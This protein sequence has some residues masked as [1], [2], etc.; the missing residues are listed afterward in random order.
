MTRRG[1]EIE[2]EL[3]RSDLLVKA[4]GA[5]GALYGLGAL[6]PHVRAAMAAS[7][8]D[9]GLL[10]FMLWFEYMQATLYGRGLSEL[11]VKGEKMPLKSEEKDLFEMLLAQERQHIA[12]VRETIEKLGGKPKREDQSEF[13]FSFRVFETLLQLAGV[14]E[15]AAVGAYNGAIPLLK[16]EEARELA[17]SIV[18]VEGRHAALVS[19]RNGE[20][21][22]LE[23]FDLGLNK[24]SAI[25]VTEQFTG[26]FLTGVF[27]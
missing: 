11:N 7:D 14:V 16:S 4:A 20:E 8:R 26:A 25:A 3:S 5:A 10:N 9:V 22:A 21:P 17:F 1:G 27:Q 12:A 18:Q 13:A 15:S 23:A 19:I 24:E 6:G 2:G